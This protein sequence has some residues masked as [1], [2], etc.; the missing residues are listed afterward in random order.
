MR[1]R[2]F[3]EI[4]LRAM[5]DAAVGFSATGLD[6]H[7]IVVGCRHDGA[8]WKVVLERDARSRRLIVV[9]AFRVSRR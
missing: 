4:D 5:L 6:D 3:T 8:G 9:T 7:R 2:G 1:Q